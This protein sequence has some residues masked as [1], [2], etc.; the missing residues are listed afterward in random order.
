M[1]FAVISFSSRSCW[2]QG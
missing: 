2:K 1:I